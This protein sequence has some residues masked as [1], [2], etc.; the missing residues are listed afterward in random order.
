VI[1]VLRRRGREDELRW[2]GPSAKRTTDHVWEL[3]EGNDGILLMECKTVTGTIWSSEVNHSGSFT[4]STGKQQVSYTMIA[5]LAMLLLI[6]L[7]RRWPVCTSSMTLPHIMGH[8]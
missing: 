1:D 3:T 2:G 7:C 4:M 5:M 6:I 8:S